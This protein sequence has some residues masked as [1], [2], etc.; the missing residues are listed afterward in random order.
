MDKSITRAIVVV[1]DGWGHAPSWGGNAVSEA[2]TPN[3]DKFWRYFPRTTLHASGKWVGLSG[4]ERGNS[5]VGHLNLGAGRIVMQDRSYLDTQLS[6]EKLKD[7]TIMNNLLSYIRKNNS[8]IHLMGL[9][10]YGGIHSHVDHILTLLEFFSQFPDVKNKVYIHAFT[11]GRDSPT[12]DAISIFNTVENK[13]K[14]LGCGKIVT[15]SGRYYAM[16]RDNH[17]ERTN[18]VYDAITQGIGNTATSS[19]SG[20]SDAYKRGETDEFIMPTVVVDGDGNPIKTISDNDA[21]IFF[22]FRSDRA[23]Q[24]TLAF[25][26]KNFRDFRRKKII[27]NLYFVSMVPY[28]VEKDLGVMGIY[29]LFRPEEDKTSVA[30]V[31]AKNNLKQLHIAETEKYAHVT[32]FFNGGIE[33]PYIG[34]DRILVNSPSVSTYDKKPEMSASEIT[35]KL[36]HSLDQN[37]YSFVILNYANADMVGHT[38]DYRAAIEACETVD[39]QIGIIFKEIMNDET[40]IILTA[41]HGNAEQMT[42]PRTGKPDTEHTNNPVP[43]I[44]LK[45]DWFQISTLKDD[46]KL[47]NVVPTVLKMMSI[48]KPENME[49]PLF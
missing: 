41:D 43:C 40:V 39:R 34:E 36:I 44:I 1:M 46:S 38:G 24:L 19:L 5:E 20:I 27:S 30:E 26:K 35:K 4:D 2:N 15:I 8:D 14:E 6:L 13:I 10:S 3:F 29:S 21:L 47:A 28:G 9:M 33:K 42:N 37:D 18:M 22:N 11:D 12:N 23:R 32:Y 49:E 25:T 17:W 16:D 7:N 48:N 45:P 31:F